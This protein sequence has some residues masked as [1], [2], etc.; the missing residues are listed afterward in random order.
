MM[1]MKRDATDEEIKQVIREIKVHG[2]KADVCLLY[3]YPSPRD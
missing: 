2:L 1:I 3:T